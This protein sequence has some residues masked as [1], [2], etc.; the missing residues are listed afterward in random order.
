[1]MKLSKGRVEIRF[2]FNN[3]TQEIHSLYVGM[4]TTAAGIIY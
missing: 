4:M 1:M 2:G 3:E